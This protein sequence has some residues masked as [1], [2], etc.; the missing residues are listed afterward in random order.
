MLVDVANRYN[1]NKF[2]TY[3][4]LSI[5]KN[6]EISR[7]NNLKLFTLTKQV[8]WTSASTNQ[9]YGMIVIQSKLQ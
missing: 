3:L 5:I 1:C 8:A 6:I 9:L 4:L 2:A 7:Y